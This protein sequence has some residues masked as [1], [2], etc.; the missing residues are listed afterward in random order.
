MQGQSA[1]AYRRSKRTWQSAWESGSVEAPLSAKEYLIGATPWP[2]ISKGIV[3]RWGISRYRATRWQERQLDSGLLLPRT[4]VSALRQAVGVPHVRTGY[5]LVGQC[6]LHRHEKGSASI[7]RGMNCRIWRL[8]L[9]SHNL[10]TDEQP[11]L[12]RT[13]G[14]AVIIN[15]PQPSPSALPTTK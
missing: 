15:V 7:G 11:K 6:G 4:L 14:A 10:A 12:G 3:T 5:R 1:D 9:L 13:E 8:F 2:H